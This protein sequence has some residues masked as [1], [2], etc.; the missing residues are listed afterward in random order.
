MIYCHTVRVTKLLSISS[1]IML[2]GEGSILTS[3]DETFLKN[4][5]HPVS[6]LLFCI[7]LGNFPK[8]FTLALILEIPLNIQFDILLEISVVFFCHFLGNC[9]S[10]YINLLAPSR[11][12]WKSSSEFLRQ[13]F[14]SQKCLQYFFRQ[15][16]F[17]QLLKNLSKLFREFLPNCVCGLGMFQLFWRGWRSLCCRYY[18]NQYFSQL[19]INVKEISSSFQNMPYRR[20]W[21]LLDSSNDGKSVSTYF[22][23]NFRTWSSTSS[24]T[25]CWLATG[26]CGTSNFGIRP[27]IRARLHAAY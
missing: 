12:L 10:R 19:V 22:R 11:M 23:T 16:L 14:F 27:I 3:S 6:T 17:Q 24:E 9:S 15:L 2:R 21:L 4:G 26:S 18:Q 25:L 5:F 7:I 8:Y 13:F 1:C 20:Q